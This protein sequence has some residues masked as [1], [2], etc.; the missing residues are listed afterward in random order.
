M[1]RGR[2][3]GGLQRHTPLPP[4]PDSN[5][6]TCWR[7]FSTHGPV[8]PGFPP[9]RRKAGLAE[10]QAATLL[11]ANTGSPR[12]AELPAGPLPLLW[13]QEDSRELLVPCT[14][15]GGPGLSKLRFSKGR[16]DPGKLGEVGS[17]AGP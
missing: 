8:L 7:L 12:L 15:R 13:V 2:G 16:E 3:G 9:C 4:N 11:L 5:S 14:E 6:S 17:H 1:G 10:T